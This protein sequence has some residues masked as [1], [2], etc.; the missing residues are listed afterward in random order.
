M[1]SGQF[2]LNPGFEVAVYAK[3]G[4]SCLHSFNDVNCHAN[5]VSSRALTK[6]A[7]HARM[8]GERMRKY[9]RFKMDGIFCFST[10]PCFVVS[11]F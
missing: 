9:M 2:A 7:E 1:L 4:I 11:E 3:C 6:A 5:S 10:F 8:R